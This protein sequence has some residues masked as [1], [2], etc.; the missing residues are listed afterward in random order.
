VLRTV[1]RVSAVYDLVLALPMLL[2]PVAVARLFGAGDPQPVLNAQLNGLFTLGLSA[3][4]FWALRDIEGRRGFLWIAGVMVK[5]LGALLFVADHVLRGS[6]S[7]FLLF[8]AC[9]GTL[10][11]LTFLALRR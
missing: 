11:V 1:T 3:G 5:G 8:A 6:P 7:S 4:Y 10:A 2:A 9:D